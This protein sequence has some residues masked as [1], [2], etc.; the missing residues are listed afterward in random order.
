MTDAKR[1]NLP[2]AL[3]RVADAV[4]D[5]MEAVV[6]GD[7]PES[8]AAPTGPEATGTY[9]EL[10][11]V[12]TVR[13]TAKVLRIGTNSVYEA[14]QTGQIPSVRLGRRIA[15]PRSGLARLLDVEPS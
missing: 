14:I 12:L 2:S 7:G 10:P 11:L 8:T 3:Y 6:A 13:E 15:V 5:V 9:T 4:V 1:E